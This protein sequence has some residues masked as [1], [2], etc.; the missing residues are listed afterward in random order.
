[1][2]K[3]PCCEHDFWTIDM[4]RER[5][6]DDTN[7]VGKVMF[8]EDHIKGA[9]KDDLRQMF[10]LVIATGLW[11][12]HDEDEDEDAEV[13]QWSMSL[14]K[15]YLVQAGLLDGQGVDTANL[16]QIRGTFKLTL[17]TLMQQH[18]DG[19]AQEITMPPG[20]DQGY[21]SEEDD[22]HRPFLARA[23]TI[24]NGWWTV[25]AA[26]DNI[27][28]ERGTEDQE[29]SEEYDGKTVAVERDGDGSDEIHGAEAGKVEE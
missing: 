29:G 26:L 8:G 20:I 22:L 3:V 10:Y 21:G 14:L 1:M 27:L 12:T 19:V 7:N 25:R 23:G 6:L 28:S 9:G 16:Q 5:L 24:L 13:D 2:V 4:I 11:V 17:A 15:K 18:G